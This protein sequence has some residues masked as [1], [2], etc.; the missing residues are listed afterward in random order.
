MIQKEIDKIV[1]KYK[2]TKECEADIKKL[3]LKCL[4]E[5]SKSKF[6][7]LSS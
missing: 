2:L 6:K 5:G 4:I 3:T 7:P 1:K